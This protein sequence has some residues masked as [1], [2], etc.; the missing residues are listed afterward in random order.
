MLPS[1]MI[2]EIGHDYFGNELKSWLNHTPVKT[3][4]YVYRLGG[5]D[6]SDV[7]EAVLNTIHRRSGCE[8][9]NIQHLEEMNPPT[10]TGPTT[11]V[12]TTW[13][14]GWEGNCWRQWA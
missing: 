11:C 14:T 7:P 8:A 9:R 3:F 5:R 4:E 13:A 6:P 10:V 2:R 1:V 12:T